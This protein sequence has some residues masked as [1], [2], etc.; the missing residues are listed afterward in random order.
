[1]LKLFNNIKLVLI[2]DSTIAN[3]D[4][5]N[6][7]F[8]KFFLSFRTLNFG[9]SVD[10]MQSV[11]WPVCNMTL[12][13][14]VEYVIFYCGTNDLGHNSPLK[15]AGGLINVACISKKNY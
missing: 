1:M 14:S 8:D 15:I 11:L 10:K 2:E 13:A 6:D 7:I 4:K 5:S 12:P 9:I 3:F